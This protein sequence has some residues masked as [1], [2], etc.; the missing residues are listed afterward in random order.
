MK[1]TQKGFV[2]LILI[3]IIAI[4]ILGGGYYMY[5]LKSSAPSIE[6]PISSNEIDYSINSTNVNDGSDTPRIDSI[7]PNQSDHPGVSITIKG[8]YLNGFEGETQVWFEN[9]S[10]QSGVI[11]TNSYTPVGATSLTFTLPNR[12]C[13]ATVSGSGL[14]C[15]SYM[16][17]APGVYKV[18]VKP[19]AKPSNKLDF[20]VMQ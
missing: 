6:K 15:P 1:N 17:I 2:A 5:S 20:T 3:I 11:N 4:I 9:S 14:P 10:G 16:G 18:Y 7:A 8:I 19:W 12:L 13:T